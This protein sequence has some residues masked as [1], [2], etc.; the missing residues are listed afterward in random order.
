MCDNSGVDVKN[1]STFDSLLQAFS[2]FNS[3]F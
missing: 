1:I 2:E 3:I